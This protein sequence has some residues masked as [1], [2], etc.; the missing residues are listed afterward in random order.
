MNSLLSL[1]VLALSTIPAIIALPLASPETVGAG[2]ECSRPTVKVNSVNK[3]KLG[4]FLVTG[5]TT[6]ASPGG[7]Q[8]SIL[9]KFPN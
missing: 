7:T 4:P 1:T 2:G 6:D 9:K 3:I 5:A 8:Y